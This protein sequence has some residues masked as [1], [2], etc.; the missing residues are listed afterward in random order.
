MCEITKYR[1][2]SRL[3]ELAKLESRSKS[4]SKLKSKSES[5]LVAKSIFELKYKLY[6]LFKCLKSV[7][8][9]GS[10]IITDHT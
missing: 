7:A 5:R 4:E 8:E 9:S 1:R 6:Y 3:I 10:I 2:R